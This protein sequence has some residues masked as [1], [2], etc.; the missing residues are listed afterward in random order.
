MLPSGGMLQIAFL[1]D[2]PGVWL[3]HC[4][5]GWHTSLGFALTFVERPDEIKAKD[6]VEKN[7]VKWRAFADSHHIKQRDSGV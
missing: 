3:L 2:N 4:H 7:C 6:D 1:T 5:I